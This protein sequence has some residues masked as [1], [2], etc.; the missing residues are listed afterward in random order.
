MIPAL[1]VEFFLEQE[2]DRGKL[3]PHRDFFA[4]I[5][6]QHGDITLPEQSAGLFDAAQVRAHA[7]FKC[8]ARIKLRKVNLRVQPQNARLNVKPQSVDS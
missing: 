8:K 6:G 7:S 4:K 3:D 2:E 5:I 1:L